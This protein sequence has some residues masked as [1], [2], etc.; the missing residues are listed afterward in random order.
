MWVFNS[1]FILSILFP[2]RK[3]LSGTKIHEWIIQCLSQPVI[4]RVFLCLIGVW[5]FPPSVL[6]KKLRLFI[7]FE[8]V[9]G[10]KKE[11]EKHIWVSCVH[12]HT[13]N[14]QQQNPVISP[15]RSNN[16]KPYCSQDG[17]SYRAILANVWKRTNQ[18]ELI[19]INEM[20]R[21]KLSLVFILPIN[22]WFL[23]QP[24]SQ[25]GGGEGHFY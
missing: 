19:Y 6:K 21:N 12:A 9:L 17:T 10:K 24:I 1:F 11:T 23:V 20:S 16:H 22:L 13:H 15:L 7:F 25:I 14:K 3:N 2:K 4:F 8:L 5:F 18:P